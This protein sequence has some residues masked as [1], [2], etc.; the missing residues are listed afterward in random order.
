M[1]RAFAN[2]TG[3]ILA[4]AIAVLLVSIVVDEVKKNGRV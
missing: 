1:F 4:V 3:V 2:I